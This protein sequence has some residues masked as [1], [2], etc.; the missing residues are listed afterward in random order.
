MCNKFFE[1]AYRTTKQQEVEDLYEDWAATYDADVI[2]NGYMTPAR[3]ASAL[4]SELANR[5]A[6]ILDFACGTGL[7]GM[8]VAEHGYRVIDGIDLSESMLET[9]EERGIYRELFKAEP[10]QKPDV[11]P[12][13]YSAITA[14]GAISPGAAPATYFDTLL[15]CLAPGGL[16]VFSYNEHTLAD[17]DYTSRLDNALEKGIVRQRFHEHGDHIQKLGSKSSVYVLE[18]LV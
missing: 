5:D 13:D 4:A 14:M 6:P 9:A 10:D 2:E 17:P 15:D 1:R 16:F 8:A 11:A 7:S 18:K 3:C 12:G